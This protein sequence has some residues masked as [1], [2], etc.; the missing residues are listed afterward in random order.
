[1]LALIL[2]N[3]VAFLASTN[4]K[5][6][7]KFSKALNLIEAVTSLMFLVDY[8]LRISTITEHKVYR[9]KGP[10]RG[11]V[12]WV[13]S[14]AG[15]LDALS[16]FPYFLDAIILNDVL[17]SLTWIRVFR[18]FLLFRTSKYTHAMNTVMRV[19]W[20]NSE[21]LGVTIFMVIFMVLF[22]S[23]LLWIT[24]SSE[25]RNANGLDD[26]LSAMYLS[27]LMLTGQAIPEGDLQFRTRC[28]VVLTAFLSVPFF[29][30]PAAM[31]TWGFEGEAERLAQQARK[32]HARQKLY[33]AQL[34]GALSSSSSEDEGDNLE[35]YLDLVGGA[36]DED[37]D[38]LEG[39]AL[40]F[41]ENAPAGAALLPEA[42]KLAKELEASRLKARMRKQ[43]Q[44]DALTLLGQVATFPESQEARQH[45]AEHCEQ[46]LQLFRAR[47]SGESAQ[48]QEEGAIMPTVFERSIGNDGCSNALGDNSAVSSELQ[49]LRKE[50]LALRQELAPR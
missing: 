18:V 28:I 32:H 38:E 27:V 40:A 34:D 9:A 33:G 41:F 37:T 7:L 16:T 8:I 13:L 36:N 42:H 2:V 49:A 39:R 10:L 3:V 23:A 14:A 46:R 20:V 1:M 5:I 30:V 12:S 17:P 19:V 24:T 25:E 48:G 47:V 6:S 26:V 22:T 11:R 31:L 44:E 50:I 15:I 29:A 35:D 4:L 21:I 45:W 43:L